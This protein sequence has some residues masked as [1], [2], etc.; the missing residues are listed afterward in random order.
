[1]SM[2]KDAVLKIFPQPQVLEDIF[3]AFHTIISYYSVRFLTL[4]VHISH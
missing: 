4:G 3:E 1:M 2:L